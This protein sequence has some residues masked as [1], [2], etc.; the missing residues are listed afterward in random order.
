MRLGLPL[1]F[2]DTKSMSAIIYNRDCLNWL[3]EQADNSVAMT[4]TSPPYPLKCRRYE[5]GK[6]MAV[7][8]WVN[9]IADIAQEC[10]RV[11]RGFVWMVVNNPIKDHQYVPAIERL[12]VAADDR[13]IMLDRPDI[14]WKNAV[15][16]RNGRYFSNDYEQVVCFKSLKEPQFNWQSVAR[17]P[18][19]SS[20]GKFRQR[21]N[22][23]GGQRGN[24]GA[25]PTGK[26]AKPRDVFRVTV[27]GGHMGYDSVDDKFATTGKAP[28]P[29]GVADRFILVG[30]S[31]DEIVLDPF[32]G[33]ATTAV[34]AIRL[35]RAFV[36][37][38]I[39]PTE[40]GNAIAR[41]QRLNEVTNG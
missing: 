4:F 22:A 7:V 5:S 9:W 21:Q 12:I 41:L 8:D 35:G 2:T 29:L 33:S 17:P 18:K 16:T 24:G 31:A 13:G 38:E 32:T 6:K 20:G 14:W 34:S 23:N 3:R 30:S 26:L 11:S 15:P 25:Y 28:F 37:C 10:V 39:C 1:D 27:G 36:G 19:Y 40:Y